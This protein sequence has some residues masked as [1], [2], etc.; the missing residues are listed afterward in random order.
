MDRIVSRA[1]EVLGS[2][3]GQKA[4]RRNYTPEF[5]LAVVKQ[6]YAPGAS[7]AVVAREHGIN[8]NLVFDWRKQYREGRMSAQAEPALLPVVLA[9]PSTAPVQAKPEAVKTTPAGT[10][11]IALPRGTISIEGGVDPEALRTVLQCL[12][13]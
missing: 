9:A 1:T 11:R 7:V 2:S 6:T 13:G 4:R 3:S 5:R 12:G 10:I 8:A